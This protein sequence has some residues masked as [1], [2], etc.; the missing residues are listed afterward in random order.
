MRDNVERAAPPI[1]AVMLT[2]RCNMSCSHCSVESGPRISTQPAEE[3]L[4]SIVDSLA[5][6]GVR[7]VL[8][9]GGEP[10]LREKLVLRLVRSAKK[11]GMKT[12]LATNGFWAKSL[13]AARAKLKA[14]QR[15]GLDLVTLSYDRYHAEF[16]G[17]R[18]GLNLCRAAEDIGMPLNMSITRV[19]DDSEISA[20]I[21]PFESSRHVRMRFYDVQAVGRARDI[22]AESL[23]SETRGFCSAAGVP[24]VTDDLRLTACNGPA[25][26]MRG[27]SPL[28]VGSLEQTDVGELLRRHRDDPILETIRTFGPERLRD[29]MQ[30]ISE[31]ENV[32]LQPYHAGMCELCLDINSRPEVARAL[33]EHLSQP[34]LRS[35]R[36]AKRLIIEGAR[37]KGSVGIV[38]ANG[39]GIAKLWLSGAPA[40]SEEDRHRIWGGLAARVF[41]RSDLD[42]KK[43]GD[44]VSECGV[45]RAIAPMLDDPEQ[46]RWAPAI[47]SERVRK[48]AVSEALRE[49]GQLDALKRISDVLVAVG[50]KGILLKGA[51]LLALESERRRGSNGNN[52]VP[53]IPRRSAGDIDMLVAP[54]LAA[55]VRTMLLSAGF[56]GDADSS[57]TGPHHLAPI[58]FRGI[59]V[60]IHTRVMPRVWKLP[61]KDMLAHTVK[62]TALPGLETLDAEGILLHTLVHS[63]AHLYSRGLK[64]AWDVEWV[65]QFSPQIDWSR[66]ERWARSSAT[67]AAFFVPA[68]VLSREL[69]LNSLDAIDSRKSRG[70][71]A[72]SIERVATARM[73]TAREGTFEMNPFTRNA[74]HLLLQQKW[75]DRLGYFRALMLRE[76]RESRRNSAKRE[77]DVHKPWSALIAESLRHFR[78]YRRASVEELR[79]R[80]SAEAERA[81]AD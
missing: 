19:A 69:E 72:R 30:K 58:F 67:P 80:A 57:R 36:E 61:E 68:A 50:T 65:S 10:M 5:G 42:W 64:A 44:Y 28:V 1:V 54:E 31:L 25:Y 7:A 26:F 66:V 49:L 6:A 27:D 13:P 62:L 35:E 43:A 51:S 74:F 33:R 16:Q 53:L 63:S 73:F 9:T 18:P 15:A 79:L 48:A 52:Q 21:E 24:A 37:D 55:Q 14:L 71:R 11:A 17:P 78:A 76:E 29:E 70:R 12:A 41:G 4:A 32:S 59:P 56:T 39:V 47:F 75:R 2:R 3:K 40:R 8:I 77:K 38:H 22:P 34:A 45:A 23:R 81:F 20:L 46:K 60:E